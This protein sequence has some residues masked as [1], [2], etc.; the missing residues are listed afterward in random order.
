MSR[1]VMNIIE[2]CEFS[3]KAMLKQPA[4]QGQKHHTLQLGPGSVSIKA[5]SNLKTARGHLNLLWA[6]HLGS[7]ISV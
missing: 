1:Y 5:E 6:N 3:V 7:W 4:R 2:L